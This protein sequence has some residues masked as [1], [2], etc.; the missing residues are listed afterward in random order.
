MGGQKSE[1]RKWSQVIPNPDAVLYF[2]S[3][4]DFDVPIMVD[5]KKTKM[6]ESEEIWESVVKTEAFSKSIIILFLNKS[7]LFAEKIQKV[8]LAKTFPVRR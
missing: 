3:L 4:P 6:Q 1:R 7:D 5:A 2:T 8:D